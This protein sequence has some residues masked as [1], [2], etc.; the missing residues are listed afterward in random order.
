MARSLIINKYISIDFLKKIFVIVFIFFCLSTIMN[1]F[2]EVNFF[3][4][5]EIGVWLPL[6]I[7]LLIVPNLIYN[8]FPFIILLS[9]MWLFLKLIK[10]DEIIAMKVTGLSNVSII[11]ISIEIPNNQNHLQED[12]TISCSS[13]TGRND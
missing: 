11:I 7:S 13:R 12:C 9:S 1:L 6:F 5:L 8:L 10:T 2:E 3:K 4:D